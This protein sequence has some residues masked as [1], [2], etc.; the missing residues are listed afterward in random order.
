MTDNDLL[1]ATEPGIL[2]DLEFLPDCE[3]LSPECDTR[4]Q[5]VCVCKHCGMSMFG[6]DP[7]KL[8]SDW[9]AENDHD[10]PLA[11]KR[12]HTASTEWSH[13]WEF[14]PIGGSK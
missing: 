8:L 9:I 12:C 1:I 10:S 13:I 7:C 4:S 14:I 6:C 3:L 5:W 11:C 2:A